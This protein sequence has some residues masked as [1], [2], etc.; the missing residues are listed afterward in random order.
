LLGP[1]ARSSPINMGFG[2]CG[3]FA[4][5]VRAAAVVY[6]ARGTTIGARR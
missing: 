3:F 5:L 4:A 6:H 2:N 1:S